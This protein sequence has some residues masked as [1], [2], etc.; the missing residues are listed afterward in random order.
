MRVYFRS[1]LVLWLMASLGCSTHDAARAPSPDTPEALQESASPA[2]SSIAGELE[3]AVASGSW[4]ELLLIYECRR[5]GYWQELWIFGNGVAIWN[6]DTQKTL[7]PDQIRQVLSAL[8]AGGFATMAETYGGK[9]TTGPPTQAGV[10]VRCSL[11]LELEGREHRTAQLV[12]GYQHEPL[13]TLADKIYAIAQDPSPGVQAQNLAD[14]LAKIARGD[15]AL[16]ALTFIA[17]RKPELGTA[18]DGWLLQLVKGGLTVRPYRSDS[19]YGDTIHPEITPERVRELARR[20]HENGIGQLPINLWSSDYR[21]IKVRVLKH[22]TSAVARPF[23]GLTEPVP[24]NA[25]A[26]ER[27]E[28]LFETIEELR[29]DVGGL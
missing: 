13:Q 21:E 9:H 10:S 20:L 3:R 15:L 28:G 19:G 23:G 8:H 26:Q 27:F 1:A 25:A 2:A 14:G 11:N 4:D 16:E 6:Q 7:E 17:H 24:E 22:E 18:G 29:R 12:E 5:E